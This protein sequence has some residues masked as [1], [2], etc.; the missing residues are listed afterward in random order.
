MTFTP[1]KQKCTDPETGRLCPAYRFTDYLGKE[2]CL[3]QKNPDQIRSPGWC[4][5]PKPT[6]RTKSPQNDFKDKS[7]A[8]VDLSLPTDEISGVT[9][10]FCVCGCGELCQGRSKYAQ[11]NH[12]DRLR[13]K[14]R[15]IAYQDLLRV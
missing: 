6:K 12:R 11:R 14:C 10:R 13:N 7:Y 3:I 9:P 4:K 2:I 8:H 1:T 15:I 5:M